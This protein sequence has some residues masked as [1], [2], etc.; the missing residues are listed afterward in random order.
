MILTG[1]KIIFDLDEAAKAA[2]DIVRQESQRPTWWSEWENCPPAEQDVW[3]R[4]TVAALAS[5]DPDTFGRARTELIRL[6]KIVEPV[7]RPYLSVLSR[8]D[9]P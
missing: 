8:P 5:Y 9:E 1:E 2:Y 3:R 6:W 7:V 4:A